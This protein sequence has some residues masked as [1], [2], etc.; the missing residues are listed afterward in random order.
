MAKSPVL[1]V[2]H[3]DGIG[4]EVVEHGLDILS[5]ARRENPNAPQ[6][7]TH[8][9]PYDANYWASR[10]H[11]TDPVLRAWPEGTPERLKRDYDGVFMMPMGDKRCG[12]GGV[13][14]AMHYLIGWGRM[15]LETNL[16]IRPGSVI[17]DCLALKPISRERRIQL[18]S[19]ADSSVQISEDLVT[20][21]VEGDVAAVNVRE[22]HRAS[23]IEVALIEAARS[24]KDQ[25][26]K[27]IVLL[28]KANIMRC[29]HGHYQAAAKR[30][31]EREGVEIGLQ[32]T[33]SFLTWLVSG[34]EMLSGLSE[35]PSIIVGD[36][37]TTSV[38]HR[39][40]EVLAQGHRG[41][42]PHDFSYVF[43]RENL[44]GPYVDK[45]FADLESDFVMQEAHH[46]RHW[47]TENIRGSVGLA[48]A[49]GQNTIT[50]LHQKDV[51]PKVYRFWE[52]IAAAVTRSEGLHLE[53]MHIGDMLAHA[54]ANPA[55]LNHR[56]FAADN[57]LGDLASDAL[58]ALVGGLGI[59]TSD[60]VNTSGS[61]NKHLFAPVGG[62]APDIAGKGIVDPISA[63]LTAG[64]VL[65]AYD[66][67]EGGRAVIDAIHDVLETGIRTPDLG[68]TASTREFARPAKQAFARRLKTGKP[69][70][71]PVR[72]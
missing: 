29:L 66:F 50:L 45:G 23:A 56:V 42:V 19:I 31:Q 72:R 43:A 68:G 3:G 41:A 60:S 37:T 36:R 11:I 4:P 52:E 6:I 62:S 55:T 30:V 64:M 39:A 21:I 54:I 65:E 51:F 27:S 63:I 14:H 10:A 70:C 13:D 5:I 57:L 61:T 59:V 9:Q 25:G 49:R 20:G 34:K 24:A 53:L 47:V 48:R 7:V 58:A 38:L 15:A 71:S 17:H 67:P 2:F 69:S 33:D 46:T 40:V 35:S 16:H 12:P 26:K 18:V 22:L 8:E 1:A 32:L 44:E 28:Q